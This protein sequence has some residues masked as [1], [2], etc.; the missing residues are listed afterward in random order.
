[1]LTFWLFSFSYWLTKLQ[2]TGPKQGHLCEG[3]PTLERAL[4]RKCS[5]LGLH[6][7][8]GWEMQQLDLQQEPDND[9]KL[10]IFQNWRHL[11]LVVGNCS[12]QQSWW[13]LI[14]PGEGENLIQPGE[15]ERGCG[16]RS[17]RE[18]G[19]ILLHSNSWLTH[20]DSFENVHCLLITREGG[21]MWTNQ[22]KYCSIPIAE[23]KYSL[24]KNFIQSWCG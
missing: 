14:Q 10:L 21:R 3:E 12:W 23:S 17:N 15:G 11:W 16:G 2:N 22:G 19:E 5:K 6:W 9:R 1:M 24:F 7:Q 4:W 8:I 20:T 13:N 18:S